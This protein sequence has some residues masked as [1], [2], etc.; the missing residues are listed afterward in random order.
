M[1]TILYFI[2]AALFT[3]ISFGAEKSNSMNGGYWMMML[4]DKQPVPKAAAFGK[5]SDDI[6]FC[7]IDREPET[8]QLFFLVP[9]PCNP[10][11]R[12]ISVTVGGFESIAPTK[13]DSGKFWLSGK[14]QKDGV[15]LVESPD[16]DGENKLRAAIRKATEQEIRNWQQSESTE[17]EK[18]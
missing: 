8:Q 10:I 15:I 6:G 1:K 12:A 14:I 9:H 13:L 5:K 3:G 16:F 17:R 7:R 4:Q 11:V 18:K 2:V